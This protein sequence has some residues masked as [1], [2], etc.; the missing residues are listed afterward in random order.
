MGHK[1]SDRTERPTPSFSLGPRIFKIIVKKKAQL[2][3][4]D[5]S[6]DFKNTQCSVGVHV[7]LDTSAPA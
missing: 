2:S 6:S 1:E 5:W 7:V 4:T 3:V